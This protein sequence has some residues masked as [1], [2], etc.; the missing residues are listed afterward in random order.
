MTNDKQLTAGDIRGD[1]AQRLRC[2]VCTIPFA[3]TQGRNRIEFD[4]L[5]NKNSNRKAI[6]FICDDCKKKDKEPEIAL[7]LITASD[8]S[9]IVNEVRIEDLPDPSAAREVRKGQPAQPAKTRR[10]RQTS[11]RGRRNK[12]ETQDQ[13]EGEDEQLA[14][15]GSQVTTL[16]E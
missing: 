11:G 10:S 7:R 13:D 16:D 8:G 2:P 5:E 9:Q 6:S 14:A 3:Q 15:A 1:L 12:T 4:K